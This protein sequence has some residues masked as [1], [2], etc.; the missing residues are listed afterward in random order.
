MA[1]LLEVVIAG[2]SQALV[3]SQNSNKQRPWK[4]ALL[5]IL[6]RFAVQRVWF[7]TEGRGK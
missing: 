4:P 5:Q 1:M 2:P 3:F 6:A 7:E